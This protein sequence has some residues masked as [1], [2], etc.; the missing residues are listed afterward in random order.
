MLRSPEH[1]R[2]RVLQWCPHEKVIVVDQALAFVGGIDFARGRWDNAAHLLTDLGQAPVA[3]A[4]TVS[5][6]CN[7]LH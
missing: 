4:A 1:L 5:H 6:A 7:Y 3:A 2:T